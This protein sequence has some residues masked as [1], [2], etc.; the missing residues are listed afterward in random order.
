MI[1]RVSIF[2]RGKVNCILFSFFGGR[3][4]GEGKRESLELF[5]WGDFSIFFE[6]LAFPFFFGVYLPLFLRF[7]ISISRIICS[8]AD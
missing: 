4:R 2:F 8:K 1:V 6:N 3:E 7:R 5:F